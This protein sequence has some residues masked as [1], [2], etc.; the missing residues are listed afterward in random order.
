MSAREVVVEEEEEIEE[1][2]TTTAD[3]AFR[4]DPGMSVL[5]ASC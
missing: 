1:I 3:P 5:C 2:E 4:L